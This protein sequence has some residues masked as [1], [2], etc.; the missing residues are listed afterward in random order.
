VL[1]SSE[2]SVGVDGCKA[3]W[4]GVRLNGDGTW[5]VEPPFASIEGLWE[6]WGQAKSILIDI[7]IGLPDKAHGFRLCDKGAREVL[8]S[9]RS[10]SVFSA[11]SRA[12]I[13]ARTFDKANRLNREQL[14]RGLSKQAFSIMPKIRQVDEFLAKCKTARRVIREVHP[15]VC[16]WALSRNRPMRYS[17]KSEAGFKERLAVLR[18][19][20]PVS[21][22]I[23]NAALQAY[24]RNAVGRDDILDALAA[25]VTG[26]RP[27]R[28]ATLPDSPTTDALGLRIEIVYPR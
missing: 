22:A 19:G 23:V 16:F 9:P 25:A 15:E 13:N 7:P 14:Q 8:R 28:L 20:F 18:R 17:K 24:P 12:A 5:A 11:P 3:G 27:D 26:L 1:T 10:C 2:F 6:K 21:P 4:F